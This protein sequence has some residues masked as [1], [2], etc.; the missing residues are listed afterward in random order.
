MNA[1]MLHANGSSP[2]ARILQQI[3]VVLVL[4]LASVHLSCEGTRAGTAATAGNAGATLHLDTFILNLADPEQHAYLRVGIDLGLNQTVESKDSARA[5][6]LLRDTILTVLATAKPDDILT[7]AGKT[8][9]K[10]DLLQAL[11]SR[12]PE[13]GVQDVYFTEFLIQ[14]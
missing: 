9:L 2:S 13:L 11:R 4:A 14:R 8:E 10:A 6:A 1:E 12:A 3:C 5:T 7:P